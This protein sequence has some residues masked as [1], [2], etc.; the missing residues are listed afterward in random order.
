MSTPRCRK[1]LT[2]ELVITAI[3]GPS[4]RRGSPCPNGCPNDRNEVIVYS[5]PWESRVATV[6]P[7]S[8]T[9]AK[10][11]VSPRTQAKRCE[12]A[13]QRCQ[14]VLDVSDKRP[15]A[16]AKW[17]IAHPER[18]LQM[19]HA[20]ETDLLLVELPIIAEDPE[21]AV[22]DVHFGIQ[23]RRLPLRRLKPERNRL[24]MPADLVEPQTNLK[25]V[26]NP[27]ELALGYDFQPVL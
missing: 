15:A 25:M 8:A 26:L 20:I 6:S 17:A 7:G 14:Y 10:A 11:S 9:R 22:Q 23:D 27:G 13:W 24:D 19:P 18:A 21:E 16:E 3:N 2:I 12:E 4:I 5:K 1:P